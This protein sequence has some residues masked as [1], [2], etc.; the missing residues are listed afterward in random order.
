M[1]PVT[2]YFILM[3]LELVF[4]QH[5]TIR[6]SEFGNEIDLLTFLEV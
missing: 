1:K 4:I 3:S 6:L 5:F 2:A